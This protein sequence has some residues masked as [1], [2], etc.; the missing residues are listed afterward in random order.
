[1]ASQEMRRSLAVSIVNWNGGDLVLHCIRSVLTHVH[2]VQ[3]SIVVVDNASND[4]SPDRIG[5]EFPGVRVMRNNEN[6]GFARANN[7]I[8]REV[9]ADYVLLLNPDAIIT[10]GSVERMVAFM[11]ATPR[12]GA[13]SPLI[14][15]EDGRPQWTPTRFPTLWGE[16]AYCATFLLPP[17]SWALRR[18]REWK[19]GRAWRSLAHDGERGVR[20]DVLN[21]ACLLAR[22][23]T[24]EEVGLLE[25]RFFLFSEEADWCRRMARA[26][27]ERYWVPRAR[28]V[29]L[30]GRSRAQL[31]DA[32]GGVHFYRSRVT[33][34]AI[35][36]GPYQAGLVRA[37]YRI[38]FWW[39]ALLAAVGASLRP[40]RRSDWRRRVGYYLGLAS[41]LGSKGPS[42]EGQACTQ[43][44]TRVGQVSR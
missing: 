25:E 7:Q 30:V 18:W 39:N 23:S 36:R 10:P 6:V 13:C 41:E 40:W 19:R 34:F 15:G 28:V 2:G 20:V 5:R 14:V 8:L 32:G 27:W 17:V 29:H 11:D 44:L 35:H 37:L 3:T 4:G 26:G 43:V 33:L 42:A 38:S 12:A 9:A 1:M 24:V 21:G 22:R 31:P 16:V